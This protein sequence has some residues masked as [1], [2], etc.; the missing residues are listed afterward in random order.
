MQPS[1][2]QVALTWVIQTHSICCLLIGMS[3][4]IG[5][6]RLLS[7]S[8]WTMGNP[9]YFRGISIS[10]ALRFAGSCG[11]YNSMSAS[12]PKECACL[13]DSIIEKGKLTQS[14]IGSHLTF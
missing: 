13:R 1:F 2:L 11:S 7:I 12:E 8:C 9:A 6:G 3:R 5:L 10:D 14:E 4:Q